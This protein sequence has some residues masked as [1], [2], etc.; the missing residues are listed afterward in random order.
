MAIDEAETMAADLAS[1]PDSLPGSSGSHR[2]IARGDTV[3]RY[4]MIT[5]LG[6]GTMGEV[7][8]AYDPELDRK[9]AVKLL[10]PQ[11]RDSGDARRHQ[12]M[13]REAQAL[14]KLSHPNVVAIHDV[15]T[16]DGM[17]W[18]AMEFVEGE[19]LRAWSKSATRSWQEVLDVM[20]AAGRG[21]VA[22]HTAG[23]VHRDVKPE[24]I[25]VGS[26]PDGA[27][28]VRVMD[29]GLVRAELDRASSSDV[30]A[31]LASSSGARP[32]ALELT[33]SG[34]VVGTPAYMAPEQQID[35]RSDAR[36]DQ[37]GFCVTL[38]EC[39]FGQRPF[40]GDSLPALASAIARGEIT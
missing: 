13:L 35:P 19:T 12:R 21:L 39:L 7:W 29:F 23:L 38:W 40:R 10:H 9:L 26:G 20:L 33:M 17:V 31:E 24:N 3:G 5:R 34:G 28:R 27:P 37:F 22:A 1:V 30:D 25:M 16:I 8:A 32:L 36:G 6:A 18:L 14:A 15:G 2:L 11:R 4:V